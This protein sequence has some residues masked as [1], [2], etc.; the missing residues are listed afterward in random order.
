M[1]YID[2]ICVFC[3]YSCRMFI[4]LVIFQFKYEGFSTLLCNLLKKF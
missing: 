2:I 4:C 3:P 1:L